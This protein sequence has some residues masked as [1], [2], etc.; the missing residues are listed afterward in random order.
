MREELTR[1]KTHHL[2]AL[3]E[4]EGEVGRLRDRINFRN[5]LS[6]Q[7]DEELR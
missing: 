2:T 6:G 5:K 4:K 7:R 1:T 3:A